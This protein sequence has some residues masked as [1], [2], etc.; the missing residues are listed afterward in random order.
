MEQENNLSRFSLENWQITIK[1]Y[2]QLI[3]YNNTIYNH[4]FIVTSIGTHCNYPF[5]IKDENDIIKYQIGSHQHTVLCCLSDD[6]INDDINKYTDIISTLEK[7]GIYNKKL[8]REE[9]YKEL[10][11]YKYV[12][13]PSYSNDNHMYYEAL[14]SGTIP[15]IIESKYS[16]LLKYKYDNVPILY[17]KDYSDININTLNNIYK[18]YLSIEYNFS[19][20]LLYGLNDLDY[21]DYLERTNKM[22][23]SLQNT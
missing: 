20:L 19:K 5:Y 6:I 10:P 2:E 16:Y 15:I 13:C 3:I 11:N 1:P 22:F 8:T 14:I 21:N 4:E 9:Y 23:Q 12:I 18:Y 7:N 17:T